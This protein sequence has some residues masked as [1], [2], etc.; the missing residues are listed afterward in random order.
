MLPLLLVLLP[1]VYSESLLLNS[2][3]SFLITGPF[4]EGILKEINGE[5]PD[6]QSLNYIWKS[7]SAEDD[8]FIFCDQSYSQPVKDYFLLLHAIGI[9]HLK[10]FLP[11]PKL[12]PSGDAAAPDLDAIKCYANVFKHLAMVNIKPLVILHHGSLPE[13]ITSKYGGWDNEKVVS[14]FKSYANFAFS[15]FGD[16]VDTWITFSDLYAIYEPDNKGNTSLKNILVAHKE[17]YG[18]YQQKF[19][20]KECVFLGGQISVVISADENEFLFQK[21]VTEDVVDFLSVN[22]KFDC[23]SGA[24]LETELLKIQGSNGGGRRLPVLIFS[25]TAE[26]CEKGNIDELQLMKVCS[27]FDF[28]FL[29]KR[30]YKSWGQILVTLQ[31]DNLHSQSKEAR[32]KSSDEF[33]AP[34]T[35]TSTSASY[36]SVLDAFSR[37]SISQRDSFL[38]GSFS[39]DFQWGVSST[40]FK[41]EGGWAEY[42]KGESIWDNFTH[43]G[44]AFNNQTADIACDS[45][46]KIDYDVYLLR[47]LNAKSYQFSISWPRIFPNGFSDSLNLKGVQYYKQLIDTLL[48]SHISPIVTLFHWD[49]PQALQDLGGWQNEMIIDAFADFADFCF[50]TFGGQV[51]VWITF[52]EP[53]TISTAGYATGQHPPGISDPVIASYQAAHT[54]IKAHAKAYHVY[55]D[56]YHSLQGGMVGIALNSDWVEPGNISNRLDVAAADRYLE[57]M[58]GWFAHP[59]FI[60]GD[61][62]DVLKNQIQEKNIQCLSEVAR[63]PVFTESE[64]IYIKG[65]SDF[66][67]LNH[68]T[69]RLVIASANNCT[70]GPS[71]VG[72]FLD[73]V[74]PNWPKTASS[75][76]YA[77]PWG[78]RRLL[79]LVQESYAGLTG[80][81]IYVTGNGMPTEYSGDVINDTQRMDFLSSYIN[82]ALK[83]IHDGVNLKG[84]TVRSLMDGFEGPEG[85]SERFGLHYVNF[86]DGNRPRTPK[87]SAYFFAEIIKNNGFQPN[88]SGNTF[89]LPFKPSKQKRLFPLPAS[90]VPSNAKVV[91][92]RFSNQKTFDRDLYH[93]GTFPEGFAW[94]VSSSSYQIEGGWDADGKG[95]SI[96]DNFTHVPNN[97]VNNDNGDVACDSYNKIDEDLYMLRALGVKM[98]RFSLSWPRIF[99]N[100]TKQSL[101][102][103]GVAYYNNLINSLVEYNITPIVTL[104]HWDLPQDLQDIG[105][106]ENEELINLFNE[107]ADFCFQT[108]GNRVKFW[109]TFN[110]PQVIAWVSYGLGIFPPNVIDPGYSPYKVAHNLIKAH[111]KAYHTYEQYRKEQRGIVSISLNTDWGEPKYPNEPRELVA[112]DRFLQFQLGWFAHPIFKNGDYP[113]AMKWQVGNKSELQG[114]PSSRLPAFSEEE[115][116]FIQGTADVFCLNTYTSKIVYHS[117]KR[118]KPYSYDDDRDVSEEVKTN[119]PNTALKELKAVAWGLRRLLNWIKEEYNNPDIY[120]TENGV[121]TE[122]GV[123]VDD[124]ERIYFYKT[125]INEAL[126]AHNLDGVNLKGY[127]AWSL[128]DSFEWLNGYKVGFGLHHVDFNNP[129]RQRTPKR[130]AHYFS[131]IIRKNGF[132]LPQE[133]Q[134]LYGEFEKNFAWSVSTAS[135]QIEG[136]WREDGKGLSIWDTF[137]HTPLKVGN[138]DNGDIACDSYHRIDEDVALLKNLGLTHYRF[139][140]SWPR[141]LPDGTTSF[142]NKAGLKYYENLIDALL[143]ANIQPQVTIYH[144]DLP[145]ALQDVKG[146]ENDTIVDRFRDYANVLFSHLGHKVKFWITLN[147]PYNVAQIGHGYGTAAPGISFRPGTAPYIV[148]HNLIKAHAEAWHLYNDTYRA[149]QGGIISLSINSDWAEPRNPYKQEDID[150]A[151]RFIQ[152]FIGWFADPVFKNGDYNEV[153]KTMIRERSLAQGLAKSRLPEFTEEEKRRIKGTFDYFGFNHY[154]TVLAYNFKYATIIQSYDADRAAKSETDRSWLGSGSFW[155]KVTP[156]GFRKILKYI[157]DEYGNPPIYITENGISERGEVDLNDVWRKHYY[158]SY[159]NEALKAY[160][161]DGADI[162]GYTAWTL[163]D[164]LEWATG[165][166][167]RFGLYYVNRSDPALP[168]IAKQSAGHYTRIIRCNGFPNDMCL[169]PDSE[170][171]TVAPTTGV[172]ENTLQSQVKFLGLK[173]HTDNAEIGL[174]ILLALAVISTLAFSLVS[175]KFFKN[176]SKSINQDLSLNTF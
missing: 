113:E 105:G 67:G 115:K 81:P 163:M 69:S 131:E 24:N 174:Y 100:G 65:T 30:I 79:K 15:A 46:N 19:S 16:L 136:A 70:V 64:K 114:L 148:A 118:L 3:G 8:I 77:V 31:I 171:T 137:A 9:T 61:Y 162:R 164:N 38:I 28:Q 152:F 126:K 119:W 39:E 49:L 10:I 147:E 132:P 89:H 176:K 52:S 33:Q 95:L 40:S 142:I 135:Y 20:Y 12:L 11:W 7:N 168:R 2:H 42:G 130:S 161:L 85:Y 26:D 129:N 139:S 53:W 32:K 36:Q 17:V 47:G 75:W 166:S 145:Q 56:K 128:M 112:A 102:P 175:Y 90:E 173:L 83:A 110:E 29:I 98:Y 72:D 117:T 73:H 151:R 134:F 63:L 62:P 111:A 54:I 71:G 82:E 91:W 48:Q 170:G 149:T 84:F 86:E 78:L 167:D 109:M 4:T 116:A 66:F 127:T 34:F 44:L 23:R 146:W 121:G 106:W 94:G 96:W 25:L 169:Q 138:D 68:Y 55:K 80:I 27:L 108:F 143:A 157:K 93:Y 144:W 41:I 156:F 124:T 125:Y 158:T 153:M 60:N 165:F 97:T 120:I 59:I 13:F 160:K 51:K 6:M 172:I 14:I 50:A 45:Y 140:I 103:K 104:Y 107:Y 150:A 99:S 37:E 21:T 122:K 35:G 154:T 87:E 101:N 22:L 123:T 159:I 57:F 92:E 141:I 1:S 18:L 43:N 58:L 155:L 74:D 88:N 5:E 133:E 76:I